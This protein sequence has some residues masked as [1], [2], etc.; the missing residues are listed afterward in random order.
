M[1]ATR[2]LPTA[3]AA[4]TLF[5][6]ASAIAQETGSLERV[7]VIGSRKSLPAA[8]STDTL[9]PV[10]IYSMSKATEG[11]GQFDLAQTLQYL[12]PSFNS[13]RQTGADGADLIDSAALR[14]LGSD[15]TL[16]LVNGKRRHTVAL[17]NLFGARNRGATGT[18]MNSIPLLAIDNVQV[19][20]DGAAAQYGSDAIAGVINIQMKKKAGCEAVAGFGQYS[21]GDGKN[22]LASAYCGVKLAGGTLGITGEWQDRGRSNRAEADNPRIIGD[23]KVTNKT[24]YLNGEFPLTSDDKLYVTAGAQDR[25]ASSAAFARGGIGS[26]DIPSRNSAAMYPNGFVP[27]INGDITDR[28]VIVGW[29]STFAGWDT[30]LSQ[31][32]GSNKLRYNISNTINASIANKDLLA[33]GKGVSA[34]RFDAG[35][36]GFSQ[37][38]T[39]LDISRFFPELL[40][41]SNIAFGAEYRREKYDIVAGELGSYNDADGVGFGGNA[42][43]QGF[44]GFQPAD[45]TNRSRNSQALYADWEANFTPNLTVDAAVRSEHY[46]DFGSSTTAK[47]AG[48]YKFGS[49]VL[50][51]GAASTG[52]RAPSLQQLYFSST[53][54]DF[55]SGK[56]L[57]VVLAPNGSKITTAAGVPNLRQEKSKNYTLGVTVKPSSDTAFTVDVYQIKI[58]DRIVLSGRFDEDNYPALGAILQGL[59]VGQAQFFVNSVN[60]KTDGVDLTASTRAKLGGGTL[61]TFL[62]LNISRTKVTGVNAPA[63]L[64]GFEDVLLSERER[65]FIEQGGPRA[66]ATLGFEYSE[67]AWTGEA[68]IIHFGSQT[69][70][71]F[72]GTAGGEPNA[73][74][75]PKTSM[76]L[77][78]TWQ[79]TPALKLSIGGNNVFNVKPTKQNDFETDN[80]FIYDSVQFGLNGASYFARMHYRF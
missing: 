15:Q 53:F 41:G 78:L 7:T 60:T 80:G 5:A 69:L 17:V 66:K 67:G 59:G 62:A 79:A 65:L 54:T 8:S 64:K 47:L 25:D 16:V 74:Y 36:F 13:T 56:P 76:D 51:R 14:G 19:L 55:I 52:F 77:G 20:R 63:S 32:Y 46:S 70:G 72:T 40:G 2:L 26:D 23:T 27:F 33:G 48:S 18:D 61:N 24:V 35:G 30:D 73:Y 10:D 68:K 50:L 6:T 4:I 75:K 57:D 11:G 42:G 45:A 43:S 39:N 34:T 12:S 21:A 49:A 38:T 31:T 37:A 29:K 22:Y 28:Y 3:L 71:T 44:P 58:K 9:V 1:H